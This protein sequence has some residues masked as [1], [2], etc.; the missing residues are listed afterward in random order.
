VNKIAG[1]STIDGV[2]IC[3]R[4]TLKM[5]IEKNVYERRFPGARLA[6]Q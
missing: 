4:D 6:D 1:F 2:A 5:P 3:V